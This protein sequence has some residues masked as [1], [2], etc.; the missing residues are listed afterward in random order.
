MEMKGMWKMKLNDISIRWQLMVIC[1]LLVAVPVAT[2]GIMSYRNV[3]SETYSQ[4]EERLQQQA[5]QLNLLVESTYT[6]IEENKK[7]NEEMAQ[8]IVSSQAEALARFMAGWDGKTEALK[9]SIADIKVGETGY[10]WVLDYQGDYIVSQNRQRDGESL[11]NERDADGN[12]FIQNAISQARRLSGNMVDYITYAWKNEGDAQSRD[13]ITALLHDTDRGWVIGI[14]VYMDELVDTGYEARKLNQLKDSL[15]DEVVGKTGYI[16]ILNEKGEYELSYQR[17]QDGVS[18]RDSKDADGSLF[19]QDILKQG[20]ALTDGETATTY[21]TWQNEGESNARTKIVSYAYFPEWKWVV[22]PSAYQEDFL[23]GLK[24][25]K[26]LTILVAILAVAIGSVIAYLFASFMANQFN[27]LA[28]NMKQVSLG[29]LNVTM[30]KDS[31]KNEIGQMTDAMVKMIAN[32]QGTVNVAEKLADGDL[33]ARVEVRSEK[34][35]LGKSLEVMVDKLN[36]IVMDVKTS[37]A[38]VASGS[39]QMSSTSEQMSQ[40]A[41]EQASAAEEA[42][43]SMEEMSSNIRQNADNSNQTEKI[44]QKAASDAE[45]GGHAVKETVK[46]MKNIAE[47]I[48]VIEE[49]A[50]QTD[51]LALNA[52]IEA[53]RA[54]E[55]GKGFAVVASEV[56]K[57]S[58][59]SQAAAAEISRVSAASVEMA[60]DAGKMLEQIVP[61]IKKTAEL[62]QEISAA[63]NEQNAGAEQ[64]NGAIQQLDQVI[65]QNASAAEEMSSTA[66]ELAGQAEQLLE[67]VGFFNVDDNGDARS[68]RRKATAPVSRKTSL[69]RPDPTAVSVFSGKSSGEMQGTPMAGANDSGKGANINL[70]E[71]GTKGDRYDN[72]FESY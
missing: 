8:S 34:D 63:S 71:F 70:G 65:Q 41:T 16:F 15:A 39:Q 52:A 5:L 53:A 46:A 18:I 50:R 17:K 19:V 27:A 29:D 57:L 7:K 12:L 30:D 54:G 58:E 62:V 3:Q 2:L 35:T 42:S 45:A 1:I 24:K 43:S 9:D 31:G 49:I 33:T 6:E 64:I 36:S 4:I 69:K 22:A 23:D 68:Y 20:M 51:L 61:D 40:G 25:I 44:A 32:L 59:K 28:N 48:Q 13:K 21:Y 26:R 66:E 72:E 47:K 56:R 67:L 14:G 37:A 10:I 38:N 60:E 55:H 11:W